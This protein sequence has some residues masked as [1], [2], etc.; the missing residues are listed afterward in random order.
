MVKRVQRLGASAAVADAFIGLDREITVDVTEYNL[1]V[2]DGV[3]PGGH[4]IPTL[5]QNDARY[6]QIGDIVEDN[7]ETDAILEKTLG[8]GV[9][10][11]GVLLKDGLVD[12]VDVEALATAA[13]AHIANVANPHVVTKTQVG[14]S[15]VTNDAQLKIASNLADLANAATARTN[16]GVAI[17]SNVQ[18]FDATL[19]ALAALDGTVGMLAVTAADT[20]TRRTITGTASQIAVANGNGAGNPTLSLVSDA[21]LPGTGG[22]ALPIGTTAQ[23]A[24]G[25]GTIRYNSQTDAFEFNVNATWVAPVLTDVAL[26]V[27]KSTF[28]TMSAAATLDLAVPACSHLRLYLA[29]VHPDTDLRDL[30]MRFAVDGVPNFDTGANYNY[31]G[32]SQ[33]AGGI[34]AVS[35]I[36]ATSYQINGTDQLGNAAD[37][38][39]YYIID[40]FFP[41]DNDDFVSVKLQGGARTNSAGRR[42]SVQTFGDYKVTD[43]ITHIRFL[44]SGAGNFTCKYRMEVTP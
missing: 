28:G 19:T 17:G 42:E 40:F 5:E 2:H 41:N 14:L 13:V 23:R 43:N 16:L 3:T 37:E 34:T 29:N 1:R 25:E 4:R 9:T 26:A 30:L 20:F 12:G 8:A 21:V 27:K 33:S 10:V 31:M 36:N 38:D 15:A 39:G 35:A 7:I 44:L 24:G 6:K 11:D 22:V 32:N 18:A